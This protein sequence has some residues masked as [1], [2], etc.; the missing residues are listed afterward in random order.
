MYKGEWFN[1]HRQGEGTQLWEDGQQYK[2][3]W[4]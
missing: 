1:K 2:G 3:Y 4:L